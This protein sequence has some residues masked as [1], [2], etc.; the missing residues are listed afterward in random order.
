MTNISR[1]AC[2]IAVVAAGIASP[3][4][5]QSVKIIAPQ[6]RGTRVTVPQSGVNSF[7]MVPHGAYNP[8]LTGGGSIGYNES[9]IKDE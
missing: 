4:F 1:L 5:A 6:H 7:A 8:A 3:A 2:I 9:L